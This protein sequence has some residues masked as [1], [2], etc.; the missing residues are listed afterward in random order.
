MVLA[1]KHEEIFVR[2]EISRILGFTGPNRLL[3]SIWPLVKQAEWSLKCPQQTA[4]HFQNE[5]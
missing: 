3:A 2:E 5:N 4:I 1:Y